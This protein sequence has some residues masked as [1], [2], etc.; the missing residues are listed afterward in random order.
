VNL[1][2][3][4]TPTATSAVT[5]STFAN[6]YLEFYYQYDGADPSYWS[7]TWLQFVQPTECGDAHYCTWGLQPFTVSNATTYRRM[8]IPVAVLSLQGVNGNT[9]ASL[10]LAD[11]TSGV[12][13]FA[14]GGSWSA[15]SK[16]SFDHV[17]IWY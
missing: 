13:E 3:G 7:A 11:L 8:Q 2:M 15:N 12:E 10:P 17:A 5:E 1:Q 4:F 16:V 6:A 14:L 9:D